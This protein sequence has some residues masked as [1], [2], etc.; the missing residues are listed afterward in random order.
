MEEVENRARIYSASMRRI[1]QGLEM[2]NEKIKDLP[3]SLRE[4]NCSKA[5]ETKVQEI[6]DKT[7]EL[8]G[9]FENSMREM[10]LLRKERDQIND[11]EKMPE[12]LKKSFERSLECNANT[13][14]KETASCENELAADRT[15]NTLELDDS[16]ISLDRQEDVRFFDRATSPVKPMQSNF[17]GKFPS[18]YFWELFLA[19]YHNPALV[20]FA[21]MPPG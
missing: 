5:I 21:L 4:K 7:E 16:P 2:L 6:L 15:P 3:E 9:S 8:N 14:L 19:Q 1:E 10:E 17:E 11:R 20:K 13:A 18:G 12:V